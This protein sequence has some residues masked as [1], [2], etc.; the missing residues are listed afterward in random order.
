MEE[1]VVFGGGD[2]SKFETEDYKSGAGREQSKNT[3]APRRRGAGL[4]SLLRREE[5]QAWTF[6]ILGRR[7]PG[8]QEPWGFCR[9]RGIETGFLCVREKD[10]GPEGGD[11]GL[12]P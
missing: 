7:A 5:L 6:G 11:W 10:W 8:C 9:R 4:L 3:R 2:G 12:D 1:V